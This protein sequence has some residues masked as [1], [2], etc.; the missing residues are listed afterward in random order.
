MSRKYSQPCASS[1]VSAP[2]LAGL[3]LV[4]G[5]SHVFA[6]EATDEHQQASYYAAQVLIHTE[7]ALQSIDTRKENSIADVQ[8]ALKCISRVEQIIQLHQKN[9][10]QSPN[11]ANLERGTDGIY[12][13]LENSLFSNA[14]GMPTLTNKVRDRT[15]Y[16]GADSANAGEMQAYLDTAFAKASLI[17][18]KL[19]LEA[20]NQTEAR[21]ALNR[22]FEAVY[23][24]PEFIG[25]Q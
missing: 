11:K 23:L 22:V 17:T 2:I 5:L 20:G 4:G 13:A 7:Q 24:F 9:Q 12:P 25:G 1:I 21:N 18:A 19:A 14:S 10:S 6:S 8:D 16:R 3:V 15:I